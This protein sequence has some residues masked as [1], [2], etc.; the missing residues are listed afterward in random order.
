MSMGKKVVLTIFIVAVALGTE[1]EFQLRI[2][3]VGAA[4]D[5][6]LVP[7]GRCVYYLLKVALLTGTVAG[8]TAVMIGPVGIPMILPPKLNVPGPHMVGPGKHIPAVTPEENK[9]VEQSEYGEEVAS[10]HI[11]HRKGQ[12]HPRQILHFNG[13][14]IHQQHLVVRVHGGKGKK[15]AEIQVIGGGGAPQKQSCNVHNHNTAE[16]EQVE[17]QGAPDALHHPA[18]A[19]IGKEQQK[20]PNPPGCGHEYIGEKPPNLPVKDGVSV[21]AD[22]PVDHVAGIDHGKEI[23]DQSTDADKQHQIGDPLVP[24][25]IKETAPF[26]S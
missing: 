20:Q 17:F 2:G 5:G 8:G 1:A 3:D 9:V 10:Y 21:K 6:A 14:D 15:Q 11:Q 18:N 4:A 13:D 26:P 7:I 16:I 25:V 19:V 23:D 12:I 24:V 22:K